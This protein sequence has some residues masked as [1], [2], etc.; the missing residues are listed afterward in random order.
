[1]AELTVRRSGKAAALTG[2]EIARQHAVKVISLIYLIIVLD[3]VVRK[4]VLPDFQRP[5]VFMRDPVVLYL[6]I[7]ASLNGFI[8][9]SVLLTAGFILFIFAIFV[10]ML[11]YLNEPELGF[12]LV[13]GLRQYFFLVPLPFVIANVFRHED[14]QRFFRIN[15][16]LIVF[17]APLMVLQVLAPPDSWINTGGASS[18]LLAFDNLTFGEF[19]RAPGFFTSGQP[20]SFFLPLIGAIILSI[21]IMRRQERPCSPLLLAAGTFALLVA[22]AASGNRA[23]ILGLALVV[24][25]G[26]SCTFL[27]AGSRGSVSV[28]TGSLFLAVGALGTFWWLFPEQYSALEE[29]WIG[30]N[31]YAGSFQIFYRVFGDFT[32]FLTAIP[33]TPM[34]GF[35]LGTA[36][37]AGVIL[38]AQS[39]S[40]LALIAQA[41]NDWTRHIVELGPAVGFLYIAYRIALT[42]QT[43]AAALK[44]ITKDRDP[45]P[46]LLYTAVAFTVLNGTASGQTTINGFM[47]FSIGLILAAP[48]YR[49]AY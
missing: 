48:N 20:L 39:T 17:M 49:R 34:T 13:Y 5:L 40:Y 14:L 24:A 26:I 1:M 3:G 45:R 8:R 31:D 2:R 46:W 30:A 47:W 25:G 42:I 28:L 29:R 11:Q 33:V 35:G 21:L 38:N 16:L 36:T 19:V 37:N 9:R 18:G 22:I 43:G 12:F 41:E 23:A 7:Y 4:Y 32:D 10:V 6:Y 15:L 27:M 44:T